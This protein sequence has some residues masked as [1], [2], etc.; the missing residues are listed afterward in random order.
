MFTLAL[1]FGVLILIVSRVLGPHVPTRAKA[2][3][4]ESGMRPI[5]HAQR[6]FPIRYYL[7][8]TIF[9]I[10]DVEIVF[11]YP[12]AVIY[13]NMDPIWFWRRKRDPI[14]LRPH[15]SWLRIS[16]ERRALD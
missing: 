15:C 13:K 9:I 4:Y 3:P 1:V 12:W 11:L 10:F 5:G 2:M 16:G 14:L 6:R 7:I 8:A